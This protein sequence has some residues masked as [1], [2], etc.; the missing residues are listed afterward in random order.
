MLEFVYLSFCFLFV[1]CGFKIGLSNI[2]EMCGADGVDEL[3]MFCFLVGLRLK[4]RV[5]LDARQRGQIFCFE[6]D[7]KRKRS[8]CRCCDKIQF[9]HI[10]QTLTKRSRHT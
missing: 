2:K 5:R 6:K 1:L 9:A 7:Q 8:G 4:K 3:D 10:S